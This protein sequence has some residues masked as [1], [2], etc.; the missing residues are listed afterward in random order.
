MMEAEMNAHYVLEGKG[1]MK[2]NFILTDLHP[3]ISAWRKASRSSKAEALHYVPTPVD[4]L[5]TD[6]K[7]LV[8]LVLPASQAH[9]I[10]TFRLF[11][12][13]FHHFDDE[14]ATRILRSILRNDEGFAIFELQGRVLVDLMFML[15]MFPFI[16]LGSW[17]DQWGNWARLFWT[18]VVPVLPIVF[19][20]DGFVSCLRTRTESE[21]MNLIKDAAKGLDGGLDGWTFESGEKLHAWPTGKLRYLIGVKKAL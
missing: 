12:L 13:S 17:F 5:S 8:K 2:A 19:A 14:P 4:A 1:P 11:S 16:V 20:F 15:V 3:D 18:G 9:G 7:D 21:L 6:S 10:K